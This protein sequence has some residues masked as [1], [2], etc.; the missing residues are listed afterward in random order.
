ML[1]RSFHFPNDLFSIMYENF[2]NRLAN[3][4]LRDDIGN[5]YSLMGDK[6]EFD[7]FGYKYDYYY[8]ND[9]DLL[10]TEFR[11][12]YI[13][14]HNYKFYQGGRDIKG[15]GGLFPLSFDIVN[16]YPR[17]HEFHSRLAYFDMND[18]IGCYMGG[19]VET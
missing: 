17:R 2:E 7:G 9:N 15:D 16:E 1:T 18:A 13:Y 4:E 10:H 5:K 14:I 19:A 8:P 11:A 6:I 3:Y 12:I